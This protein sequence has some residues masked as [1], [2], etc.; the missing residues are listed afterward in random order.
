MLGSTYFMHQMDVYRTIMTSPSVSHTWFKV[1]LGASV[2]LMFL[3]AYVELYVG[4]LHNQTISYRTMPRSTHASIGLLLLAGSCFQVALWP[5]YGVGKSIVIIVLL[6][7][8]LI[9]F[10]LM[11]PTVVQNMIAIVL[12]TF[13]LQEYQ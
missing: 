6:V 13:F 2:T 11:F 10:C 7:T 4:K 3:K 9:N 5:A 1:G 12:L 8:F